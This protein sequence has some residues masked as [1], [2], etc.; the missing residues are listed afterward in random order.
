MFHLAKNLF[1]GRIEHGKKDHEDSIRI[2]ILND[3]FEGYPVSDGAYPDAIVDLTTTASSLASVIAS[4]NP[5]GETA[6]TWQ[7]A[8][9][10]IDGGKD[11]FMLHVL[12]N[13]A[14][15]LDSFK[16]THPDEFGEYHQSIRND[17]SRLIK[18]L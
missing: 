4:L 16:T 18:S 14:Q 1:F 3:N 2:L 10:A 8:L 6:E 15:I 12:T 9:N 7:K 17:L 5:K 13:V 11:Q